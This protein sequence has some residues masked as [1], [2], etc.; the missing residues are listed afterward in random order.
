[1][2]NKKNAGSSS[3]FLGIKVGANHKSANIAEET[4]Y[5]SGIF[6]SDEHKIKEETSENIQSEGEDS[7]NSY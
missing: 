3:R 2:R 4:K 5:Y 7:T 6:Q 1:M